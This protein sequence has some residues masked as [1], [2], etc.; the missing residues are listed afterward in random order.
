MFIIVFTLIA[1]G[2]FLAFRSDARRKQR[3][4]LQERNIGLS[5]PTSKTPRTRAVTI[6][7]ECTG[8]FR[9]PR[10]NGAS[11]RHRG[12]GGRLAV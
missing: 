6:S 11:T 7:V 1:G 5:T 4:Q 2:L 3:Q 10:E 8:S 9:Q 12:A